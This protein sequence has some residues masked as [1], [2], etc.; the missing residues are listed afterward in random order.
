MITEEERLQLLNFN[1]QRL[2]LEREAKAEFYRSTYPQQVKFYKNV[3][4]Y[5]DRLQAYAIE[6]SKRNPVPLDLIIELR[7]LTRK[8]ESLKIKMKKH[9]S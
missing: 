2:E 1:Q 6:V 8:A 9:I 7:E 5:V 3:R 4:D